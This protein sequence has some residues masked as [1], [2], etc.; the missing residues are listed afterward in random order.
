MSEPG[1]QKDAM[2]ILEVWLDR[3]NARSRAAIT[4]DSGGEAGGAQLRLKYVPAEGTIAILH[5]VAVNQN[6]RPAIRVSHFE[7]PTAETLVQAGL[8]ASAQLGR[9]P[10]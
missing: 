4:L 2:D 5:L 9:R 8:W 6:G 10:A 7:G 1:F 3:Y